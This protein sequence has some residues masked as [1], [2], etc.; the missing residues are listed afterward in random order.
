[1]ELSGLRSLVSMLELKR[2]ITS[3][4]MSFTT[5]IDADSNK[6]V[7]GQEKVVSVEEVS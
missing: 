7:N 5:S 4:E 6:T 2:E 3:E 1:V